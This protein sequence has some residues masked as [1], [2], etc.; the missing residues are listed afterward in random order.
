MKRFLSVVPIALL[1]ASVC[2][3]QNS[4]TATANLAVTVG[5]EAAIVVNTSPAFASSGIFGNYTSTTTLTYYV[6]TITTGAVTVKITTDF[7]TGGA[8][9]GPSVL[10]PPTSGDTLTYTCTAVP[11]VTGTATACGTA[12]TASTTSATNVIGFA[13]TTQSAKIGDGAT[14]T[15]T[16]TNDPSYAAGTYTA[17]ATYTISAS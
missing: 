1:A 17:V 14:T 8:G 4:S 15:W 12:Q 16:L 6:R 2:H 9:G 3:A 11:P 13:S 10:S 5:A 7:S